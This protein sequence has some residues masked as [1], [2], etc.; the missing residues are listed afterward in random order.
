[1]IAGRHGPHRC[2]KGEILTIRAPQWSQC[3]IRIGAG[4]WLV[5]LGDGSFK[6][7]ATYQW[8]PLDETPTADGLEKVSSVARRL[9]GDDGFEVLAH[10]AGIRPILRRSEP[11][12]SFLGDGDWSFNGLGSKG[13]LTAPTM[14]KQ[15]AQQLRA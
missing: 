8:D 6:A 3:H 7:G 15:L 5:P 12:I 11:V 10:E 13:S 1:L 2:A 4:G 14:A 9:G